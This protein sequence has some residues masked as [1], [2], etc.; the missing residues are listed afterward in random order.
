MLRLERL[1]AITDTIRRRSPAPTSAAYLA[2]E[3]GVSRRTIERDL[4]ALRTAGVP[5]YADRGRNGGQHRLDTSGNVVLSLSVAEVSALVVA[6]SVVGEMPF[7]DAAASA[8]NRL[9]DGLTPVTRLAV[10]E[11]RNRFRTPAHELTGKRVR[12]TLEEAVRRQLV[13]NLS[14][15]DEAGTS[16]D[17]AVEAVGFFKGDDHWFL[18]G[19]CRL[20]ASGRIFR[21]DRVQ[22]AR[23]TR[24][25]F[26]PRDVT[27]TLGWVPLAV[28]AP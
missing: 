28:T 18:I 17:R 14:Y 1:Y 8:S 3:F 20:R 25:Q 19:W 27:A 26:N 10:D 21:F 24:Q 5:L 11:L 6:V 13:V 16:T 15:V 22:T 23:L 4:D 9:L 12:R 7:A 2:A